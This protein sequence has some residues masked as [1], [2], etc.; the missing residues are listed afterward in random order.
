MMSVQTDHVKRFRDVVVGML[1][2]VWPG[3]SVILYTL[4]DGRE[5]WGILRVTIE[6][7]LKPD[8]PK[9]EFSV[10]FR[11]PLFEPLS[12]QTS[13]LFKRLGRDFIY[14]LMEEMLRCEE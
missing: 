2:K 4:P 10:E 13:E 12:L 1:E 9:I 5:H 7:E 6:R 8:K 14:K 3:E 11:C